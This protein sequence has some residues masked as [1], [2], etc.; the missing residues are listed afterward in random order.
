EPVHRRVARLAACVM[1]VGCALQAVAS[2]LYVAPLPILAGAGP[3]GVFSP[4]QLQALA[5][6]S[7]K[8]N[9]YAYGA[10]LV[11]FG[12]WCVLTGY[13]IVRSTFM[14]SAIGVLLAISGLG[15]MTF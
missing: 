10:Y 11:F 1:V 6:V 5:L 8:L 9:G 3:F 2:L 4:E 7:L 12:A 14:P 13:L 15:W